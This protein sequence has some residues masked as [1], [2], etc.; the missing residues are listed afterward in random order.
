MA[1]TAS[2][3]FLLRVSRWTGAIVISIGAVVLVGWLL[4][5]EI[6]KSFGQDSVAMQPLTAV[7]FALAGIAVVRSTT[8]KTP[9]V[10]ML[11]IATIVALSGVVKA[12]G[13]AFGFDSPF[14]HLILGSM[15][16]G[17]C[18]VFCG[19]AL[20]LLDVESRRGFRPAQLLS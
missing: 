12:L 7:L 5:I 3:A 2:Q 13:N 14:D 17:V 18:F 11:V 19:S 1:M 16:S 20:L 10:L 9:D 6:L 8:R 15:G 4:N